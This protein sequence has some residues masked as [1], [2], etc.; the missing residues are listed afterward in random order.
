VGCDLP[1]FVSES[2]SEVVGCFGATG[3]GRV[4][5]DN[6]IQFGGTTIPPREGGVPQKSIIGTGDGADVEC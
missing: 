4:H 6:T 2:P 3:K 5:Y 1:G